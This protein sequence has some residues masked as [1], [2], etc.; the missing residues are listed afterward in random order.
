MERV[1]AKPFRFEDLRAVLVAIAAR[2]TS[3]AA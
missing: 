3:S 1:V 2:R